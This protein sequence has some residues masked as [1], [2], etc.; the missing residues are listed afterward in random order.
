MP[1]CGNYLF[2]ELPK[3]IVLNPKDGFLFHSCIEYTLPAVCGRTVYTRH[4]KRFF[5]CFSKVSFCK[6]F[7]LFGAFRVKY[8][9]I[10][11]FRT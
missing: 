3:K 11:D 5:L 2:F 6:F 4:Y 10:P 1:V 7:Y 8:G 9:I